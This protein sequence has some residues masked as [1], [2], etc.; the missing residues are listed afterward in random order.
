M[1]YGLTKNIHVADVCDQL[2]QA[3]YLRAQR[4]RLRTRAV[5]SRLVA[6]TTNPSKPGFLKAS[7]YAAAVILNA[8]VTGRCEKGTQPD[9]RFALKFQTCRR[10]NL[11]SGGVRGEYNVPVN[12]TSGCGGQAGPGLAEM[13]AAN[14]VRIL[15]AFSGARCVAW[16]AVVCVLRWRRC[17]SE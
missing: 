3:C 15:L 11:A 13:A 4:P 6:M 1:R 9:K 8:A 14:W 17:F 5:L 12:M 10:Q 7:L 2:A 16:R